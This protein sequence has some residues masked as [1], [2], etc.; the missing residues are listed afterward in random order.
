MAIGPARARAVG[1]EAR[2]R[3]SC[4]PRRAARWV[5]ATI[6]GALLPCATGRQVIVLS[7]Q[8]PLQPLELGGVGAVAKR[9]P[10]AACGVLQVPKEG[11][12]GQGRTGRG[13]EGMTA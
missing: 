3:A 8:L 4:C 12:A 10:A 9:V 5:L 7:E 13:E 6:L 11:K 1:T 2:A